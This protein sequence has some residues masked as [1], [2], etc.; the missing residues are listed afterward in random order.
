MHLELDLPYD[1]MV[2]SVAGITII[3]IVYLITRAVI[4]VNEN[5]AAKSCSCDW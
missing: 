2:G 5:K 1:V 4:K 3:G